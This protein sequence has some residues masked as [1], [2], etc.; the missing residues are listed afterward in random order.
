MTEI[1]HRE[2]TLGKGRT[3]AGDVDMS[4]DPAEMAKKRAL[5]S[6]GTAEDPE[7]DNAYAIAAAAG[8]TGQT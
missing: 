6:E 7:R 4:R 8:Q 3:Y 5:D 1:K 2:D